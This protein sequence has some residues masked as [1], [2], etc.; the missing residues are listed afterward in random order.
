MDTK[1]LTKVQKDR[2]GEVKKLR[3]EGFNFPN[4]FEKKDQI[5]DLVQ[6]YTCLKINLKQRKLKSKQL[7]GL[8]ERVMGNVA[9]MTFEDSTDRIQTYFS[10]DNLAEELDAVKERRYGRH[11]WG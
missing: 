3:S 5:G 10:R 6:E 4:D 8:Y 1:D 9:F 11:N 2:E 7:A